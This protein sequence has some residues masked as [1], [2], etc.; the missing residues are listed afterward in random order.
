MLI[1]LKLLIFIIKYKI[2]ISILFSIK[3]SEFDAVS[4][5]LRVSGQNK[6]ASEWINVINR[7]VNTEWNDSSN[8]YTY[9]T[10]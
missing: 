9:S 8:Y 4:N 5:L 1:I 6:T 3:S 10:A 2:L 7:I